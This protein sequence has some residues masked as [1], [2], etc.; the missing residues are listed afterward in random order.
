[1]SALPARPSV[2]QD[3]ALHRPISARTA[4]VHDWFQGYHGAERVVEVMRTGLFSR[5]NPPDVFTFHA[6]RELLPPE[7]AACVIRESRLAALPGVRQQGHNPGHWRYLLPYMQT[8]FRRLPLAEYDLVI[9]SSHAFAVNVRPRPDAVHLCYCYTPLRYAWLPDTDARAEGVRGAVLRALAGRLRRIDSAASSR[10]DAYA[11]ISTAV[12][13][14]VRRFYGRD[15]IVVHPPVEVDELAAS[16]PKEEGTFLWVHRLVPYKRPDLVL[17]AFRGLPYRL[18]MV[19]VG[20]LERG[21]RERLPPNVEL[22]GWV[23]RSELV[24]LYAQAAGFIHVGEEDFGVTMVEALASGTPVLAVARGG[25]TDIVRPGVDG[26]LLD[27]AD[28][29]SVRRGIRQLAEGDWDREVLAER[30]RLFSRER[31]LQRM[32]GLLEELKSQPAV[33]TNYGATIRP[34]PSRRRP[35]AARRPSRA[36]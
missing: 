18:L 35:R 32:G 29:E 10:P 28:I 13:E 3:P 15:A 26:L 21:L 11:V 9:S 12:R 2:E 8:Y 14:R 19:G 31:F 17:E 30:A 22:R 7:L 20:P 27:R 1:M 36:M 5:A 4:I 16:G 25:A 24:Q 34:R 33:S 6:V 23:S